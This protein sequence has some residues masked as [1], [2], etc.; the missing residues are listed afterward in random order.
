MNF[1]RKLGIPI[2][3]GWK[4]ALKIRLGLKRQSIISTWLKRGVPKDFGN[5]LKEA[6]IDPSIWGIVV[7]TLDEAPHQVP[8]IK[9]ERSSLPPISPPDNPASVNI[10]LEA[11]NNLLRELSKRLDEQKTRLEEQAQT[12]LSLHDHVN[13]MTERLEEVNGRLIKAAVSG[14]IGSLGRTGGAAE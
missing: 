11:M 7:R 14:D 8:K 9:E 1:A 3:H 13:K 5:I 12:L 2:R 6:G 4:A 10:A